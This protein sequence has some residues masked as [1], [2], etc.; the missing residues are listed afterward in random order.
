M[1]YKEKINSTEEP[2]KL[3]NREEDLPGSIKGKHLEK[4]EEYRIKRRIYSTDKPEEYLQFMIGGGGGKFFKDKELR[5][6]I[7]S[8]LI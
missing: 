4:M 2:V 6:L 8:K 5:E 1:I 7:L 3:Y